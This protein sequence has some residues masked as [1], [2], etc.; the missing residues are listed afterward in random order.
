MYRM[1]FIIVFIINI[2]ITSWLYREA[3]TFYNDR[4]NKKKTIPKIYDV[5]IKYTPDLS[6]LKWLEYVSHFIALVLPFCF[7]SKIWYEYTSYIVT[8]LLIRYMFIVLTVLPK[9]KGC[10]DKSVNITN[11]IIG[12]CYDKIFSGH[13]ASVFLLT[14]I[15]LQNGY[16]LSYLVIFNIINAFIILSLRYHY[17]ID[18]VVAMLVVM[19]VYQNKLTI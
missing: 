15:L 14:L 10:D 7:G 16:N 13:F 9:Y 11:Y 18:L 2:I 1:N 3:K 17:T 4:I 6:H 5:G 12:N 19:L 8:I